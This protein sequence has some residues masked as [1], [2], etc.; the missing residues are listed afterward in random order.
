[1]TDICDVGDIWRVLKLISCL[2]FVDTI[3]G[4]FYEFLMDE[5]KLLKQLSL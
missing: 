3:N 5:M 4:N 1:M 2:F